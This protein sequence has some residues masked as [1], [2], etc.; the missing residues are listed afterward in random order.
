[1]KRFKELRSE[2]ETLAEEHSEGG[3]FGYDPVLKSQGR[4]AKDKVEPTNYDDP[5]DMQKINAFIT[6][7]TSKS[8]V[9]P[10]AALYLLRAKL[11]LTG[12]DFELNRGTELEMDKEYS[13]PLKRFG[14]TFGT[15]PEHDLKT[16]FE[17]TNG[18]NG[19]NYELK[20]KIVAPQGGGKSGLFMINAQVV[21]A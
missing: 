20:I 2:L 4:S 9:D 5:Y 17:K 15:S 18:F 16:G 8:Y 12:V 19:R 7:F 1:M 14:G 21:E 3:G 6:A 13:F 11:H 10:R